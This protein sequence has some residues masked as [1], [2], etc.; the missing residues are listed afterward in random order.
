MI[1]SMK[2]IE[3]TKG[4]DKN[5]GVFVTYKCDWCGLEWGKNFIKKWS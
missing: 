4:L 3:P 2:P 5:E 1:V